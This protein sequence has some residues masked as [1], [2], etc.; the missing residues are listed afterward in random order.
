MSE[1]L[2]LDNVAETVMWLV[3]TIKDDF[4]T[5]SQRPYCRLNEYTEFEM[6]ELRQARDSEDRF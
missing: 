3:R 2:D 1:E 6:Y 5:D 4:S